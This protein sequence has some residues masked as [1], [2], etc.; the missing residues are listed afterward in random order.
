VSGLSLGKLA[1][2]FAVLIGIGI[3]SAQTSPDQA[4]QIERDK[5]GDAKSGTISASQTYWVANAGSSSSDPG[6]ILGNNR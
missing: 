4:R 3:A 2:G 6:E 5:R 1:K